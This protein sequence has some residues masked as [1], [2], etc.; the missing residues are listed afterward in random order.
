MNRCKLSYIISDPI[1][2][3]HNCFTIHRNPPSTP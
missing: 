1:I 2:M 3:F